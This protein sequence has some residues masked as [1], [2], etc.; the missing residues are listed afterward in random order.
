MEI[1]IKSFKVLIDDEDYE[2]VMQYKW[3]PRTEDGRVYFGVDLPTVNKHRSR[4]SLHRV[5]MNCVPHDGRVIDHINRNTL[6]NRKQNLRDAPNGCNAK[7]RKM[8]SNNTTG[9]KGVHFYKK[10]GLYGALVRDRNKT[11]FIGMYETAKEAAEHYDMAASRLH[12]EFCSPNFPD[13]KYDEAYIDALM[14]GVKDIKQ[15]NNTSGYIGVC[16]RTNKHT[17]EAYVSIDRKRYH[18]GMFA[19]ALEAAI[20]RD[21]KAIE[22]YGNKAI[23]NFPKEAPN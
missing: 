21:K 19:T 18:V 12:K 5:I 22:L 15:T 4:T 23:L 8:H 3:Q 16:K 20:A 7:N 14:K 1:D 10:A 11:W 2:K 17:W 9:Y 6:D 13:K